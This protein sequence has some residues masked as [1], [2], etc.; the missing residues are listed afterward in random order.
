MTLNA[1]VRRI[2]T[3]V[4]AHKQLRNFYYG[5]VVDFLNDKKTSYASCFLQDNGGS[6]DLSQKVVTVNF[7]MFLL[8]LVHVSEG[9]K[10]N[11]LDVQSD[12]LSVAMDQI[13][14]FDFSDYGDWRVSLSNNVT[15][16]REE[17]ADMTA[18]VVLDLSISV[19]Y[20]KDTC[21][22]PTNAVSSAFE[23]GYFSSDPYSDIQ[24]KVFQFSK[25]YPFEVE[26]IELDFTSVANEKYLAVKELATETAKT[27]WVNTE[28]NE[29]VFPDQVFR[30]PVIIGDYRYYVS[31]IPVVLDSTQFII[32]FK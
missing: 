12:M 18:G 6:I 20:T 23:W 26:Q 28:F 4:L 15:F 14:Q 29:G 1:I 19:P 16:V 22:V 21:A 3:I 11:E 17:L 30:D 2:Q 25:E 27:E 8:D 10:E 24:N 5:A 31:R 13:A 32:T 9:S 7:R